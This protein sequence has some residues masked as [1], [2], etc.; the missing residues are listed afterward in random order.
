M[1]SDLNLNLRPQRR[2]PG[3]VEAKLLLE[4]GRDFRKW[5]R[6]PAQSEKVESDPTAATFRGR[7]QVLLRSEAAT[8]KQILQ[9]LFPPDSAMRI[10]VSSAGNPSY[11]RSEDASRLFHGV[12]RS[13]FSPQVGSAPC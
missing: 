11:S 6:S 8:E 5:R 12:P 7:F 3:R 4:S 9:N 13:R 1:S 2:H 10:S